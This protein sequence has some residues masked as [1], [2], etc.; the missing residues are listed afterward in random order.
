[1]D[2]RTNSRKINLIP[3]ELAV[4]PKT[5]KLT[6]TLSQ[7]TTIG[8][9]SLFLSIALVVAAFIF[10]RL[11][12]NNLSQNIESLKTRITAL[13]SSEQKLV[14]TKDRLNKIAIINDMPSIKGDIVDFQDV[15]NIITG[16]ADS[17]LIEATI[18]SNKTEFSINSKDSSSLSNLMA[19]LSGLTKYK[20]L[21]LT[22]LGFSS[23]AGFISDLVINK[24]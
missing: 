2:N 19:P 16:V 10:Y 14:I 6:K 20:S 4:S 23:T 21:I 24:N 12:A 1:M 17:S 3:I 9:I 13:E 11:E 18:Q 22:S 15:Q 7:I 5:V 8:V